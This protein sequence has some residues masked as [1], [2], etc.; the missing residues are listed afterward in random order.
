[1]LISYPPLDPRESLGVTSGL[2]ASRGVE[3][4]FFRPSQFVLAVL[5]EARVVEGEG[6]DLAK[7]LRL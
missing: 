6:A 4:I 5:P 1:V 2:A 7:R 3:R